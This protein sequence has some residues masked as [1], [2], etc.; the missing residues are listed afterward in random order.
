MDLP[1][2]LPGY[3]PTDNVVASGRKNYIGSSMRR[4]RGIIFI[5]AAAESEKSYSFFRNISGK[6]EKFL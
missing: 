2:V 3:W 5:G 6:W 4:E 1:D